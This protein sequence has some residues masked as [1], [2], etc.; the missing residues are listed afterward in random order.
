MS[1]EEYE[2]ATDIELKKLEL[3][4]RKRECESQTRIK[5]LEIRECEL[6][7][8]LKAKNYKSPKLLQ[9]KRAGERSLT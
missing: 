7:I 3:R 8:Q 2:L 6:S 1:D 5:K 4:E 9:V